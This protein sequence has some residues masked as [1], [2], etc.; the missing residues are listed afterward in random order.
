MYK[1]KF[2]MNGDY[3]AY[4]SFE[5]KQFVWGEHEGQLTFWTLEQSSIKDIQNQT[6][7]AETIIAYELKTAPIIH[8]EDVV[9]SAFDIRYF[10][11]PLENDEVP[12]SVHHLLWGL[13]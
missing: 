4:G 3:K 9:L 7:E 2:S 1:V 12:H 6:I 5:C 13:S 11:Y 8:G 10:N